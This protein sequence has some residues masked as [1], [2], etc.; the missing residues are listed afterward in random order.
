[1]CVCVC[2]CVCVLG[3]VLGKEGFAL[4]AKSNQRNME[5]VKQERND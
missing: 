2:V 4:W 5:E 1:M 3:E